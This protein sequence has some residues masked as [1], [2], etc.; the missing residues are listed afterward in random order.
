MKWWVPFA[1]IGGLAAVAATVVLVLF[2][3][4]EDPGARSVD[5]V[6]DEFRSDDA[7]SGDAG[8][9]PVGVYELEGSGTES[10]SVPPISQSDGDVMP[11]AISATDD[12]CWTMRIDF[13]EA[14]WQDWRLCREGDRIME[15]GGQ[16]FQRWDLGATAIE[17]LSE[18][19]CDPPVVFADLAAEVGDATERSCAGTNDALDGEMVTTGVDE[20]I[21]IETIEIGGED[22]EVIHL[23][24][25]QTASGAQTGTMANH[26]WVRRS[27]GLPVRAERDVTM[28][29]DSVVGTVTYTETGSWQL[30]SLEPR[31]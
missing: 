7:A 13:N 9:P 30:R 17:N 15:S 21:G 8:G 6:V 10:L 27:D 29:T 12:G 2:L 24:S 28:D 1:A 4:R 22:V 11:M 14:H 31:R 23:R 26:L 25:D 18:F 19:V 3:T 5:E 16:T 20:V